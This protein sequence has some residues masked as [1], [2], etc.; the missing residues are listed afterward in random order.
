MPARTRAEKPRVLADARV[1]GMELRRQRPSLHPDF[2]RREEI[3]VEPLVGE[4]G[5]RHA[6]IAASAP[7]YAPAVG[8]DQ[9]E[10][11]FSRLHGGRQSHVADREISVAVGVNAVAS[12]L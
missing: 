10:S 12:L 1:R 7:A 9:A 2:G 11:A 4:P 3:L 5:F 8:D 6:G